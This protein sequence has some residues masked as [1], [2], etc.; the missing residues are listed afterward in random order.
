MS[1]LWLSGPPEVWVVS[2]LLIHTQ[3]KGFP[4]WRD[5]IFIY[6]FGGFFFFFPPSENRQRPGTC[7]ETGGKVTPS[8]P[9][10]PPGTL[11]CSLSMEFAFDTERH[12]VTR[13]SL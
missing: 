10:S 6:C 11:H 3:I 9:Y 5:Y 2:S 12:V 13:P 7:P 8:E 4:F 1:G